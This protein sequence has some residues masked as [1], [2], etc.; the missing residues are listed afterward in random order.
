[1]GSALTCDIATFLHKR[2]LGLIGRLCQLRHIAIDND[3]RV[4]KR[5]APFLHFAEFNYRAHSISILYFYLSNFYKYQSLRHH[6]QRNF[7]NNPKLNGNRRQTDG[8]TKFAEVNFMALN[9]HEI[10]SFTIFVRSFVILI[11]GR[12]PD[13]MTG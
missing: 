11:G 6:S 10:P 4:P 1:M 3:L 12:K 13:K 7:L 9:L 2:F 5:H 8:R